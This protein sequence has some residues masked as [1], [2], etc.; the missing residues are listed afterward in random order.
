MIIQLIIS[1]SKLVE[2][3]LI[4]FSYWRKSYQSC[5]PV[6][7]VRSCN[8]NYAIRWESAYGHHECVALLL[9]HVR[10]N[11]LAFDNW[12]ILLASSNGHHECVFL[13]L[14]NDRVD[15]STDNNELESPPVKSKRNLL[16]NDMDF[17]IS[18]LF[19][20]YDKAK[21]NICVYLQ[22]LEQPYIYYLSQPPQSCNSRLLF[23]HYAVMWP[24]RQEV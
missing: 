11:P 5:L 6:H 2:F 19:T 18:R 13:L 15:P 3:V 24:A 7:L 20:T 16:T 23:A 8:I 10:V 12:A 17:L 4:G 21:D 22:G 1:N 14:A 9:A